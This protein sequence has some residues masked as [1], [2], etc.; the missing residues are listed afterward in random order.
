MSE[1]VGEKEEVWINPNAQCPHCGSKRIDQ[2][3]SEDRCT[4]EF[5][6]CV[7]CGAWYNDAGEIDD[8]DDEE[9]D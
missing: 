1:D 7:D 5:Y 8:E 2:I 6:H 3:S 9:F 4:V